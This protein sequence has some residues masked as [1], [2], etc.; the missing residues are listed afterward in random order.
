MANP[1]KDPKSL[2]YHIL[3]LPGGIFKKVV[4]IYWPLSKIFLIPDNSNK[5]DILLENGELDLRNLWGED[6]QE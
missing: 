2:A 5:E 3:S 6:F 1:P 4:M